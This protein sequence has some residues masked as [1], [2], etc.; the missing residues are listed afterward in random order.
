MEI[1]AGGKVRWVKS[2]EGRERGGRI[3]G[4]VRLSGEIR[5]SGSK[6]AALPEMAAALLT[7]QTVILRN[8]P[9]V[10]DTA[11]M[12]QILAGLGGTAV[13]EGTVT[14]GMGSA[15]LGE[16]PDEAG[17]RRRAAIPLLGALRGRFGRARG[18]RPRG[19]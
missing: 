4:G 5:V 6:N 15:E 1:E 2:G 18:P 13:G 10:S 7:S 14:L 12:S 8:V 16:V 19:A 11:V 3:S 17:R 9:K